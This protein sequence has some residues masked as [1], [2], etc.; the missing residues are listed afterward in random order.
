MDNSHYSGAKT[1]PLSYQRSG[2]SFVASLILFALLSYQFID[3]YQDDAYVYCRYAENILNGNGPVFNVGERVEGF[4]SPLWL[5]ELTG[6]VS[7]G[8][9]APLAS[10]LLGI[11]HALGIVALFAFSRVQTVRLGAYVIALNGCIAVWSVGGLDTLMGCFH[12]LLI[13][14]IWSRYRS[15]KDHWLAGIMMGLAPLAR[16]ENAILFVIAPL[17]QYLFRKDNPNGFDI[18]WTGRTVVIGLL[19]YGAYIFFRFLYY[20]EFLPNTYFA[21][22]GDFS[23]VSRG[24]TYLLGW[25]PWIILP[26]AA[27]LYKS[28]REKELTS[29]VF[30]TL[31]FSL[32]IALHALW[33]GGDFMRGY[34]AV[35]VMSPMLLWAGLK[36]W[37]QQSIQFVLMGIILQIALQIL[38][39]GKIDKGP[40]WTSI[41][42]RVVGEY[43]H[44]SWP[45]DATVAL[46]TAG[47]TPF[48]WKNRTIDMLGLTDKVIARSA[49]N[50]DEAK[51]VS[52]WATVPGHRRGN[53]KSV[54]DREPEFIIIGTTHGSVGKVGWTPL[55]VGDQQIL[56]APRLEQ[57][58]TAKSRVLKIEA[59]ILRQYPDRPNP[60]LWFTYFEKKATASNNGCFL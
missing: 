46:N 27:I 44:E 55:F 11:I 35:V 58:Y 26:V 5:L 30:C 10:K 40:D 17:A 33:T 59:E 57:N 54:L 41:Y 4:T 50:A 22:E 20:G 25:L 52:P 9:D 2:I 28:I 51:A 53:G 37:R 19:I 45:H 29:A 60:Y 49:F 23:L 15:P 36:I 24:A 47:S 3:F 16:P 6:L 8:V 32:A 39:L 48:F 42:G 13:P 21:K 12:A 1:S 31:T 7:I 38:L 18:K 14:I 56:D 43:M 34:R